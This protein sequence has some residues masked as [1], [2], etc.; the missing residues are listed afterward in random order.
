MCVCVCV[1]MCV[2][3]SECVCVCVCVCMNV[4]GKRCSNIHNYHSTMNKH[5]CA[6]CL[7]SDTIYKTTS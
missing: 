1:C 2:F 3:V 4:K 6:S 7:T 5:D